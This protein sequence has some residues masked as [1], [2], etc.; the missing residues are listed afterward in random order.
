MKN[1]QL[2]VRMETAQLA[3]F[4]QRAIQIHG[5]KHTDLIREIVL[6]LNEDR[7]RIIPTKEQIDS[8]NEQFETMKLN[9]KLYKVD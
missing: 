9:T 6:A 8:I 2:V 3:E 4:K 1:D 7:L 5:K